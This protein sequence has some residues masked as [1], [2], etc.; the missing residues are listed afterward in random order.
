MYVCIYIYIYTYISVTT[1]RISSIIIIIGAHALP[2]PLYIMYYIYIYIYIYIFIYYISYITI[3][4]TTLH[5][6][7]LQ[8]V[9]HYVLYSRLRGEIVLFEISNSTKTHPS[10]FRADSGELRPTRKYFCLKKHRCD[11]ASNCLPP[12]SHSG[13]SRSWPSPPSLSRL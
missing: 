1:I 4:C 10:V 7:V 13:A 2:R 8:A 9:L 12:T 5:Y 11:E 3:T 6:Y